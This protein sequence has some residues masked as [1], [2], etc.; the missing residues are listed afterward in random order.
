[1]KKEIKEPEQCISSRAVAMWRMI[2][3]I[4]HVIALLILAALIGMDIAFHWWNWIGWVLYGL[5]GLTVLSGIYSIGVEPAILQSTW[6]Y[7]VSEEYIQLKHG[8]LTHVHVLV[9]M[10][11]VE[12]VTTNQGP[13][14]R[15][16][17]LYNIQIGTMAS[18]HHIPAVPESEA[19]ALREQIAR[20]A[21]VKDGE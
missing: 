1:M 19:L 7:D 3:M 17:G 4:G 15:K 20:L 14:M 5:V 10:T 6:R 21:Q 16:Y 2:R 13:I 11:K 12:Y 8:A 18:S 9:P